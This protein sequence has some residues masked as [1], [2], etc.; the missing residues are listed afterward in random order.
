MYEKV[1]KEL[2]FQKGEDNERHAE[3]GERVVV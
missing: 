2:M 1:E 3:C